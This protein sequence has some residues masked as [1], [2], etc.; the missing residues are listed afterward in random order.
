MRFLPRGAKQSVSVRMKR[1]SN[2]YWPNPI[3][4]LFCFSVQN[5][6]KLPNK[7]LNNLAFIWLELHTESECITLIKSAYRPRI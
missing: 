5:T 7:G 4:G 2:Y 6:E 1:N 3:D